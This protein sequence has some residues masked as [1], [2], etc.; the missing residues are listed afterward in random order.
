VTFDATAS[1][2]Y[3]ANGN[4]VSAKD[5]LGTVQKIGYDGLDRVVSSVA[6]ANGTDASN[7]STMKLALDALDQV[8]SVTDPDGLV[9]SYGFDGLSNPVSL[10]SPDT[11]AQSS[12]FDTA[13]DVLTQSDAK[14]TMARKAYDALGRMTSV[15]YADATL[16]AAFYYDEV[17]SVTGCASSFPVGRLTRVVENA[18]TTTYCYDNQGRVTEQRQTQGTVTDTADYVYTKAGRLAATA[19]PSGLVTQ[20]GRDAAGQITS[21]T[22][23]PATGPA[24]TVVSTATYLPFGPVASYTLGNGQTVTRTYDANYR[25]TDV[26]SPALSLHVARDA[27]GNI[28]ALGNVAGASPAIE[29]Y[30]YDALYRLTGLKNASGAIVEAYSYSKTGDR[31]TKTAPGL[32]MGNYGYQA[33]THQLISIGAASR[34]YDANGSTTGNANAGTAWGYGYNGRGQL[35]VVQQGGATVATYAYDAAAQRV[36]KTVGAVTTRYTYGPGGM[37]GEYGAASRDYVWMDSIPVAVVDGSS[38]NFVHADGLDTPRSVTNATGTVVWSWAYQSN[39]FGEQAPT[40]ASGYVLNLRFPGQYYDAEAGTVYNSYRNFDPS[41]GRYLQS[42]PIGL[43]GGIS[44]YGYTESNPL[45]A[46]DPMGLAEQRY[47]FEEVV[48]TADMVAAEGRLTE[49]ATRAAQTVDAT[50]DWRCKL[51]WIRGTLIHSE[52]KRLVD[53]TCP[54]E[55]FHTEVTYVKGVPARYG[56]PGGVRADVVFGPID[57]PIVVYDLKTGWAY[58]SV[59]Q[60]NAYGNNL[61]SGTIIGEIRPDGR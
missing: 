38:V 55:K 44:T 21:V 14:S 17:A 1:G 49:L 39:P 40:S 11:G 6:N 45:G 10:T 23:T 30:T 12:T 33:G 20:Y 8:K 32:A 47:R 2:S 31:L 24:S 4:L 54:P 27:V 37:L 9:T 46:V 56:S 42:D 25:F 61:P 26:V 51:P 53:A 48:P 34:T 57:R 36:A 29:T 50:C 5:A 41:T 18:V 43:T 3:D 7:S 35:T 58:I 60:G 16:N 13:G 19:S 22:V 59:S 15:S 52:F 28:V